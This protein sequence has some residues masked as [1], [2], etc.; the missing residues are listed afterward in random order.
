MNTNLRYTLISA[1]GCLFLGIG[2]L[3]AGESAGAIAR[4]AATQVA[5]GGDHTC[6][7]SPTG[8]GE[9]YCWG[10]NTY[11]QLGD[12]TTISRG[13]PVTA[14]LVNGNAHGAVA[15]ALGLDFTCALM[16][17]G[18]VQCWGHNNLGQLGDGTTMDRHQPVVTEPAYI[19]AI[20]AG[21]YHTCALWISGQVVCWGNNT[22]G[23]L[24]NGTAGGYSTT[25]DPVPGI[26]EGAV[27]I[28]AGYNHTC[29][30]RDGRPL[31]W[32]R[33]AD[34]Q[35]GT[36]NNTDYSAPIGIQIDTDVRSIAAGA[37]HTCVLTTHG[38]VRCFGDNA[39]GELGNGGS[40]SSNLP[41]PVFGLDHGVVTLASGGYHTC[42]L[43]R[44]HVQKC[45]GEGSRGQLGNGDYQDAVVPVVVSGLARPSYGI[46]VGNQHTCARDRLGAL[47]CWGH[48]SSGQLGM[49]QV[50]AAAIARPKPV[51]DF[52]AL[53]VVSLSSGG[54]NHTCV[55][56]TTGKVLCWGQNNDGQLGDGT[57]ADH[58]QPR[59]GPA[60][61]SVSVGVGWNHSCA[62]ESDGRVSCWGSNYAGQLGNGT[63]SDSLVP[64]HVSGI[65]NA[66]AVAGGGSHTCA[67][68]A[69]GKVRCWGS[70]YAGQLGDGSGAASTIPVPVAGITDAVA[71]ALGGGHS[72]A[73]LTNGGAECWGFNGHGQLGDGTVFNRLAPVAVTGI[74]DAVAIATGLW[75]TCVLRSNGGVACWGENSAGE[76][77][78]GSTDDS[79]DP[80]A[81]SEL[82]APATAIGLGQ[83]HSCAALASGQVK[84]WGRND[85]GQLGNFTR[86]NSSLP[87][88]VA[89]IV[90]AV[91]IVGGDAH[92]CALTNTGVIRCWGRNGEGELG[93]GFEGVDQVF[94][95]YTSRRGQSI[96]V[97]LPPT[98]GVDA[99]FGLSGT[100][101]NGSLLSFET[102]TPGICTVSGSMLIAN[103]ASSRGLCGVRATTTTL[104]ADGWL[105]PEQ[106]QLI[107]IGDSIFNDPFE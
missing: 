10:D 95:G 59:E 42:I 92:T 54:G 72:C 49:G 41:V 85:E 60:Q 28:S 29:A 103:A 24:G 65:D 35:L 58:P 12:G 5:A 47:S 6:E 80:V 64:V 102:W 3:W 37:Y 40:A 33:N 44:D 13:H 48:A 25:P 21:G 52:T 1:V 73:V 101:S 90:G 105:A 34:G 62:V 56:T 38:A 17:D 83:L 76:L 57:T 79:L 75:H 20:S 30:L 43:D 32:G 4:F 98:L 22:F 84:C 97:A 82:G 18:S 55:A 88:A 8:G 11:G 96:N 81:V 93:Q 50:G 51:V 106:H 86:N 53:D 67:L 70:N 14:S 19:A 94:P 104:V 9:V 36:G 78:D 69:T 66:I 27:A 89:A 100:S 61:A 74:N 26:S 15:L 16:D 7:I 107:Y 39:D 71:I 46:A 87:V 45:W 68:L 91:A 23:E 2:S 77:G 63:M 31:C 99:T